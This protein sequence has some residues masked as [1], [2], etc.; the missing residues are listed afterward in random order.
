VG[1][2]DSFKG[3]NLSVFFTVWKKHMVLLHSIIKKTQ[4]T[5]KQDLDLAKQRKNNVFAGGINNEK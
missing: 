5:P 1:S 4:K 3:R 2:K